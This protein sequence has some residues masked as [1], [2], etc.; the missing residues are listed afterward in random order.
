MEEKPHYFST[1]G[2]SS[3]ATIVRVGADLVDAAFAVK[4]DIRGEL[5][6]TRDIMAIMSRFMTFPRRD[7]SPTAISEQVTFFTNNPLPEVL[8]SKCRALR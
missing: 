2:C 5:S 6:Q 1:H 7:F 3:G 4:N 8:G